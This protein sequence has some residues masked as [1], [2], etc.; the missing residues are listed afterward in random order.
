MPV[1]HQGHCGSCGYKSPFYTGGYKGV[2]VGPPSTV[3][4]CDNQ[5]SGERVVILSHPC[6]QQIIEEHGFTYK[7]ATFQGRLLNFTEYFCK[8]CGFYYKTRKL[9]SATLIFGCLTPIVISIVFGTA[10]GYYSSSIFAGLFAAYAATT[11]VWLL[12]DWL[13]G[14]YVR[15]R[16]AERAREYQIDRVC[17]KCGSRSAATGGTLPC[18]KCHQKAMKIKIVGMS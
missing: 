4:D 8:S 5:L 9:T 6:E 2:I 7:S 14:V 1:I 17:P 11:L 16:Y 15:F 10:V 18:P 3:E 13:V 12:I